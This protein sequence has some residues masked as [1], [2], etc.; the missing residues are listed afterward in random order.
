MKGIL[1]LICLFSLSSFGKSFIVLNA[2]SNREAF[3]TCKIILSDDYLQ[4]IELASDAEICLSSNLF[5]NKSISEKKYLF[6]EDEEILVEKKNEEIVKNKGTYFT[7]QSEF[8]IPQFIHKYP[9]FDGRGVKVGVIDDGISPHHEGFRETTDGKRKLIG[10][11]SG[12]SYYEQKVE[13]IKQKDILESVIADFNFLKIFKMIEKTKK[14][15]T[16]DEYLAS[17]LIRAFILENNEEYLCIDKNKNKLFQLKSECVRDFNQTGDYI[18]LKKSQLNSFFG[19][20]DLQKKV[21]KLSEIEVSV[22]SHGEGVASVMAGHKIGGMFDGVA[23]GSQILDYDIG[24]ANDD[25]NEKTSFYSISKFLKGLV[26]LGENGAEVINISHSLYYTSLKSQQNMSRA[27]QKIIKK[28]NLILTFS[29]GNNGPGIGSLNRKSIYP[30]NSLVVG[31]HVPQKLDEYVHGVTGLP[32][33]GRV[34]YYSSR[35]P[36][37]SDGTGPSVISPLSSLSQSA[38]SFRA[39]SGTSSAAPAMGGFAAIL[40]S[41]IKGEHLK[42][43]NTTVINAIKLSGRQLP[44]IPFVEQGYGL[45]QIEKAFDL[46]K[47]MIRGQLPMSI[48]LYFGRQLSIINKST[49]GIILYTSELNSVMEFN[50]KIRTL[51]SDFILQ[52][53]RNEYFS[54]VNIIYSDKSLSGVSKKWIANR[55]SAFSFSMNRDK[56][57]WKGETEKFLEI[58]IK[59]PV[60]NLTLAYFPITI[61]DDSL[62]SKKIKKNYCPWC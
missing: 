48:E 6:F 52:K 31:A 33:E 26:I 39:F 42:I 13:E 46:Y 56:I 17:Y 28:Y 44:G 11:Y 30:K 54:I 43:D 40:L 37:A 49:S 22:D 35:G 62:L 18:Y 32:P 7:A 8:G 36:S 27:L 4:V 24:E 5:I 20:V 55:V 53:E 38:E 12:S 57:D 29:A 1:I 19:K 3:L 50:L 60:R 23:P 21:I 61:I 14:I 59:D 47:L 10:S 16:K 45:P 15:K 41:A 9:H 25:E 58:Y 2:E 51:F 34:V